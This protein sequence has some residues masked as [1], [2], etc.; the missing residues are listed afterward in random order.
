MEMDHATLD[1][2]QEDN[3][4]CNMQEIHQH[5]CNIFPPDSELSGGHTT[6]Q[7]YDSHDI[8][9]GPRIY[10]SMHSSENLENI[11]HL[12]NRLGV[13]NVTIKTE[14]DSWS[15]SL[16]QETSYRSLEESSSSRTFERQSD[17]ESSQCNQFCMDPWRDNPNQIAS[18]DNSQ[19]RQSCKDLLTET[20]TQVKSSKISE[21]RQSWEEPHKC[22]IYEIIPSTNSQYM[23]PGVNSLCGSLNQ[24]KLCTSISNYEEDWKERLKECKVLNAE[25]QLE[26]GFLASYSEGSEEM[27]KYEADIE[28]NDGENKSHVS[29]NIE[30]TKL[31]ETLKEYS[32]SL[33]NWIFFR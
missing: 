21:F 32:K 29:G 9:V 20:A 7:A 15:N 6:V 13:H 16:K 23:Q 25:C 1:G 3:G 31:T 30:Q 22:S 8:H 17:Y 10:I 19:S 2:N 14:K 33:Q 24:M 27:W 18:I 4:S 12:L 26:P 11:Y 28:G 5:G